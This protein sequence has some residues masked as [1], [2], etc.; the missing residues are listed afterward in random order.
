[1]GRLKSIEQYYRT[2]EFIDIGW[3]EFSWFYDSLIDMMAIIYIL[4]KV[5]VIIEGSL[6]GII[7]FSIFIVSYISGRILKKKKIYDTKK[8]VEAGLDPVMEEIY[9]AALKINGEK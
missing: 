5:G 1:M 4:E 7:L 2:Q 8:K 6:I 3:S 9:R